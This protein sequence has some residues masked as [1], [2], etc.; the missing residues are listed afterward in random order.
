MVFLHEKLR[1]LCAGSGLTIS[2]LIFS[3]L[4]EKLVKTE[5]VEY[6]FNNNTSN[7][8]NNNVESHKENF[9]YFQ[10]LLAILC[11]LNSIIGGVLHQVF[12]EKPDTTSPF[13]Y[14]SDSIVNVLTTLCSSYALKW[15]SY[16]V[17]IIAK[18]A[19]PIPTLVLS[20]LIGKCH[21]KWQKYLFTVLLVAGVSTFMY[22]STKLQKGL[23]D[24]L[25][26]GEILLAVSLLMDGL[27][28]GIQDRI[29][30][31]SGPPPF[32]MMS[33][34]NGYSS[35]LVIIG[36]FSVNEVT[37]FIDFCSRFPH[38]LINIGILAVVNVIGQSFVYMIL[39]T[40]GSL[41]CS[42][43]TTVRKLLSILLSVIFFNHSIEFYQWIGLAVTFSVLFLD[44]IYSDYGDGIEE[45]KL[46]KPPIEVISNDNQGYI[47]EI[48]VIPIDSHLN[49]VGKGLN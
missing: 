31:T 5:Y 14:F 49:A 46:E 35:V 17:Q 38:V 41:S 26:Y 6:S 7:N 29:R 27:C 30:H 36:A 3:L 15:V 12:D 13:L 2:F 44:T 28:G 39:T 37:Q 20:V 10:T 47:K 42:F 4:H 9:Y 45:E 16:P 1:F 18:C 11:L 48:V 34:I 25:W 23:K 32:A 43:V 8:S 24:S 40:N 21:Y 22:D 33:K 19:S